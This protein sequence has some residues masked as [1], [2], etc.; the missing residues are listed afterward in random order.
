MFLLCGTVR[1]IL[2]KMNELNNLM[3]FTCTSKNS[4]VHESFQDM[5]IRPTKTME[6]SHLWVPHIWRCLLQL[7]HLATV[8]SIVTDSYALL[9]AQAYSVHRYLP[10]RLPRK[11]AEG[12]ELPQH[13]H[14]AKYNFNQICST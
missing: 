9:S 11:H 14:A 8:L 7:P 12:S 13:N 6:P 1:S 2:R 4:A 5:V 10:Y 3:N